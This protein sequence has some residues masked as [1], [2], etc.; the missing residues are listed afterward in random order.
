M[1]IVEG[2]AGH[3]LLLSVCQ[4]WQQNGCHDDSLPLPMLSITPSKVSLVNFCKLKRL[5][6][7][8]SIN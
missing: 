3:T 8:T 1:P 7:G 4:Q 6:L 2:M 5:F